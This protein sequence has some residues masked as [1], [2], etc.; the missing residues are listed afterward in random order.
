MLQSLDRSVSSTIAFN[1][2]LGLLSGQT[3]QGQWQDTVEQIA[4]T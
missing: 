1:Q 4:F 2:W 3:E